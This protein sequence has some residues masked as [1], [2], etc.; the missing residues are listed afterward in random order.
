MNIIKEL[1]KKILGQGIVL[2][3]RSG[4][5]KGKKYRL[6]KYSSLSPFFGEWEKDSQRVFESFVNPGDVV[7]DL[8]ANTGIHTMYFASLIGP[9]GK[10]YAFE[11]MPFNLAEIELV[12][13]LNNLANIEIVANAVSNQAG[14]LDF[15]IGAHPKQG[16]LEMG[17]GTYKTVKVPVIVLDEAIEAGMQPPD[18]VKVDIEGA[19]GAAL[20]GLERTAL[21][22]F[23]TMYIELHNPEQDL[24]VGAFLQRTGYKA[25]R[26][27]NK[28][29][30]AISKQVNFLQE[31]P[32]FDVGF[33][34]PDGIYG[35]L[36]AVHPNRQS[37]WHATV[38]KL[39]ATI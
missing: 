23:P 5:M 14:M 37:K 39:T 18:F 24:R 22:H 16:S 13:R 12:K 29:S 8:G 26:V 35:L 30:V 17:I 1:G 32:R 11:P 25:Y 38:E 2:K 28:D 19:E 27:H 4:P 21:K 20:E 7:F 3:I 34:A 31:I 10:V 36:V 15:A 33:P 6:N 9:S